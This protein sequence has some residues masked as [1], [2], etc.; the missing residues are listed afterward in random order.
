MVEKCICFNKS[1][2]ELM[3]IADTN[4][5]KSI[6]ELKEYVIF[7]ENCQLCLPYVKEMLKSGMVIFKVI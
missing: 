1:F 6:S 4:H 5:C 3:E 2:N 7:G